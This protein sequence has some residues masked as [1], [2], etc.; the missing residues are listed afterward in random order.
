MKKL[1][2]KSYE[3]CSAIFN[4]KD[5]SYVS[6][7]GISGIFEGKSYF[8]GNITFLTENNIKLNDV[9]TKAEEFMKKRKD[10]FICG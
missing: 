2:E 10:D 6:G 1:I 9:S 8:I 4:V 3:K 5:F 7:R